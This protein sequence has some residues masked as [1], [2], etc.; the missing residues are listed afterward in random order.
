MDIQWP[1]AT[2]VT[3]R[4]S[5]LSV[6]A[7]VWSICCQIHPP[8]ISRHNSSSCRHQ[9]PH[10][11]AASATYAWDQ[12]LL[13]FHVLF[14]HETCRLVYNA[15]LLRSVLYFAQCCEGIFRQS[16]VLVVFCVFPGLLT[17]LNLPVDYFLR[18]CQ[19][20]DSACLSCLSDTA[21]FILS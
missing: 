1:P 14:P 4:T 12:L 20:V 15:Y 19:T 11:N 18:V 16:S 21:D 9:Y 6:L 13:S 5:N 7:F 8:A 10:P 17:M 3:I 2:P